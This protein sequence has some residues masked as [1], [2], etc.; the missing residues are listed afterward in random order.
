MGESDFEIASISSDQVEL[1]LCLEAK[2]VG[3]KIN[4]ICVG[5]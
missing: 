4:Y 5:S 1:H 2:T 3:N